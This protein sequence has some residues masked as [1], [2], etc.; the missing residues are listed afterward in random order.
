[1]PPESPPAPRARSLWGW[2]LGVVGIGAAVVGVGSLVTGPGAFSRDVVNALARH[3]VPA[4]GQAITTRERGL[5][6]VTEPQLETLIRQ[7]V[8]PYVPQGK[9][10]QYREESTRLLGLGLWGG[11]LRTS[12]SIVLSARIVGPQTSERIVLTMRERN[13]VRTISLIDGLMMP[14]FEAHFAPALPA[15]P[16]PPEADNTLARLA[17]WVSVRP[18]FTQIGVRRLPW[19]GVAEGVS[20]RLYEELL[21]ADALRIGYTP[22]EIRAEILRLTGESL[23]VTGRERSWDQVLE[24]EQKAGDSDP[25]GR[26]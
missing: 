23:T 9:V 16:A 3:D 22:A 17:G 6:G 24:G 11:R 18:D 20:P 21:I 26:S 5:L 10:T 12:R 25:A 19:R 8:L 15:K 4:I 14:R 7:A 1:M 2:A 13:G